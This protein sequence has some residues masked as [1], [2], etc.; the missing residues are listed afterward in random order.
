M[1]FETEYIL[2]SLVIQGHRRSFDTNQKCM[3]VISSNLGPILSRFRDICR[4][5]LKQQSNPSSTRILGC[6]LGL[7]RWCLGC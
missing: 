3:W 5:L 4:F 6:F 2:I 1:Y 7:D